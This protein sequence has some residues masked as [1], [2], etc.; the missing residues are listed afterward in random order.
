[1]EMEGKDTMANTHT[2]QPPID[3]ILEHSET[4]RPKG[5][6]IKGMQEHD[7]YIIKNFLL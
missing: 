5:N 2:I 3:I 4:M 7:K 1:M 6:R